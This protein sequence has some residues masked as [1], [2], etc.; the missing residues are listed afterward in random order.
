[1]SASTICSFGSNQD[2]ICG[3]F[4]N[5][6]TILP[7]TKCEEDM[8][9]H[10]ISLGV[11]WKR[12]RRSTEAK[13]SELDLILNRAGF[14]GLEA[15]AVAAMTICPKHRRELTLDWPGRKSTTCSHPYH[16]GLRKQMKTV[17]RVNASM[18]AEIFALHKVSVPVG[19][20][21]LNFKILC[22]TGNPI[23]RTYSKRFDS[24]RFS[25]SKF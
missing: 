24:L 2:S 18:S 21:K 6:F 8:S 3:S 25:L 17:R 15:N 22:I 13:I 14:F 10:L 23:S 1:M 12:G 20:G 19:S 7:V 9:S 16:Q 5:N 4:G 11:S